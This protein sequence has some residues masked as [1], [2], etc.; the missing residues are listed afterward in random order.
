MTRSEDGEQP[1]KLKARLILTRKRGLWRYDT[2]GSHCFLFSC[3]CLALDFEIKGD[4]VLGG[5]GLMV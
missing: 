4:V 3:F 2:A 5:L 1:R